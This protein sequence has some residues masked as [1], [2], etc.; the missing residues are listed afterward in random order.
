MKRTYVTSRNVA[1]SIPDEYIGFL[2]L[3]NPSISRM[4]L[5]ST[6]PL[7]EIRTRKLTG[8]KGRPARKADSHLWAD[9]LENVGS[10]TSHNPPP[11]SSSLPQPCYRDSFAFFTHVLSRVNF[12]YD[13]TERNGSVGNASHCILE[14]SSSNSGWDGI[15]SYRGINGLCNSYRRIVLWNRP[16]SDPPHCF[17]IAQFTVWHQLMLNSVWIKHSDI[18]APK[19]DF[20]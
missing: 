14:L 6:Q 9:C 1:V 19:S 4:A 5:V 17:Q 13:K 2:S 12:G 18:N 7:T 3:P 15:S 20:H 16:R 8:S 10:S 11:P